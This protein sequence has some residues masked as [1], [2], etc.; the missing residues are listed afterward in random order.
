MISFIYIDVYHLKSIG[1]VLADIRRRSNRTEQPTV[2]VE[3]YS[4]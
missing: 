3:H 1:R 2:I 4:A